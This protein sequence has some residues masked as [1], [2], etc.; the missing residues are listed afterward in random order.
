MSIE[1]K[2]VSRVKQFDESLQSK[3]LNYINS[4]AES[5]GISLRKEVLDLKEITAEVIKFAD[6]YG[7]IKA[8]VFGSYARGEAE[9]ESDIDLLLE[10]KEVIGL[11][12][13]GGLIIDLEEA[14]GKKVDVLQFCAINPQI[15]DHV[16]QEVKLIYEQGRSATE[17]H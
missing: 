9:D 2:I 6:Q 3:V 11:M 13:L 7:I 10:F 14:L 15:R 1:Y 12:K 16:L 5:N 8:G 4:L 17:I